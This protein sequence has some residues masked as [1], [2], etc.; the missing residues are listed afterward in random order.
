MFHD[1]ECQGCKAKMEVRRK[2]DEAQVPPRHPCPRCKGTDFKKLVALPQRAW[3]ARSENDPFPFRN[4]HLEKPEY[5]MDSKGK[6]VMDP[7]TGQPL[8][9][10]EPVVFKSKQHLDEYLERTGKIRLAD[11]E[12]STIGD[13]Q[14]SV[15]DKD[16]DPAPTENAARMVAQATF[17]EDPNAI[18]EQG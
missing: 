12:D 5:V 18:I 17:T 14:H 1:W 7:K 13:S 2:M 3:G 10:R 11:I 15:F 8:I 4:R 9:K 6:F 16:R